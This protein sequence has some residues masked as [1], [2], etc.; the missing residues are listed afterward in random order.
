MVDG[1]LLQNLVD[2]H[3]IS[4]VQKNDAELFAAQVP[5]RCLEV[6]EKISPTLD[7]ASVGYFGTGA[8]QG[9]LARY[10]KY[11]CKTL[12]DPLNLQKSV[13]CRAEDARQGPKGQKKMASDRMGAVRAAGGFQEKG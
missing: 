2:N 11:V 3:F 9:T 1:S 12:V 4:L 13:P 5:H 10:D 6:G 7:H 8:S